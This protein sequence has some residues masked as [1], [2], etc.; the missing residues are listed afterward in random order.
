MKILGIET[1]CD[2]TG[3]A[4]IEG[5]T[6]DQPVQLLSNVVA[7]SL[8]K[9]AQTGGII[10]EIAARE[11]VKYILP[12][13][14]EA[15]TNANLSIERPDIDVIAVTYGP[16][17]IG[18][19]LVGVE[20][21]KTLSLLW[22]IPLIPVNHLYGHI[23]ASFIS[24]DSGLDSTHVRETIPQFPALSLVVSG[25]HTDLVL[26]R[27]H[28]DTEVIGGTRDDAAGEAFDKIGRLLGLSYPAG[29]VISKL[30]E[31][32]NPKAFMLPRPMWDSKDFDFSFSGLKTSVF[33]LTKKHAWDFS[34]GQ[35]KQLLA[36]LCASVQQA[37]IDVLVQK[38][39]QAVKKYNVQSL[40]IG[41][42]VSANSRL[43]EKF[44]LE[45][46]RLFDKNVT[47]YF[48]TPILSTDN[49]AMIASAGF[50]RDNTLSW[51]EVTADPELYY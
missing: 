31:Q 44:D 22:D 18:S 33:N 20:T 37:I 48:P 29:P 5:K 45:V 8:A 40:V 2:E 14:T 19:L 47:V 3:A 6:K 51:K 24:E 39:L 43:R 1:S 10:P 49:A 34:N 13:V 11:Q 38:T 46:I 36:D 7:T 21:A 25:G 4:V 32:G 30:A 28:M 16:G 23:Y 12:V 27:G 42:G 15:L 9:H 35:N 17:L 50:Y 26:L 41:G